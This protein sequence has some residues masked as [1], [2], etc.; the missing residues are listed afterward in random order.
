M[1]VILMLLLTKVCGIWIKRG[2]KQSVTVEENMFE[3]RLIIT[4]CKVETCWYN[5]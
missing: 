5:E 4:V 3:F 1:R 2:S